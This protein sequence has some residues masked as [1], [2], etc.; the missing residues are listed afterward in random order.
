MA[1]QGIVDL[2]SP[3]DSLVLRWIERADPEQRGSE[4]ITDEVVAQ[5]YDAMYAWIAYSARCGADACE[6]VENPCGDG[7]T[8]EDCEVSLQPSHDETFEDPG[9]CSEATLEALFSAR[10]YNWRGRCM[11]CHNQDSDVDAPKWVAV[12]SCALGAARTLREV[13]DGGLIDVD[14]PMQSLLLLKPLSEADGG[15]EHGGH[16]KMTGLDDPSY[17]DFVEWIERYSACQ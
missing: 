10:V 12:G 9:D 8:V 14:D 1:E 13:V 17:L 7:P 16:D 11:P 5:E 2:E 15:V 3:E 4:L 6:P